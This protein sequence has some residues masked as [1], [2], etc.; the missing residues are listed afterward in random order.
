MGE[1]QNAYDIKAK[2]DS[3][4][5]DNRDLQNLFKQINDLKDLNW[6]ND[7]IDNVFDANNQLN[8][9]LKTALEG[10]KT[11]DIGTLVTEL[12]KIESGNLKLDNEVKG[13]IAKL[14]NLLQDILNEKQVNPASL[15]EFEWYIR[16]GKLN[17][18]NK[19]NSKEIGEIVKF[20][21][22]GG[23]NYDNAVQLYRNMDEQMRAHLSD[24]N[25]KKTDRSNFQAVMDALWKAYSSLSKPQTAVD[26]VREHDLDKI[27]S[28]KTPWYLE[29]LFN[30]Y[31]RKSN[32]E[33]W[34]GK[35]LD[36]NSSF[37]DNASKDNLSFTATQFVEKFNE[38]NKGRIDWA[39]EKW[40][41]F[42]NDANNHNKINFDNNW[43][44]DLDKSNDFKTAM[45]ADIVNQSEINSDHF[46]DVRKAWKDGY[47]AAVE[48][49]AKKGWKNIE[50]N[51][52]EFGKQTETWIKGINE[53]LENDQQFLK[54]EGTDSNTTISYNLEK[55]KNY[56]NSLLKVDEQNA[57]RNNF[58]T[59]TGPERKAWIAAV[60]IALNNLTG[61]TDGNKIKVDGIDQQQTENAVKKFQTDKDL[62]SKDGKPW[63][64]TIKALLGIDDS[65]SE[66][67]DESSGK[68]DNHENLGL[69]ENAN[70]I[71]KTDFNIPINATI[72]SKSW[73]NKWLYYKDGNNI[74]RVSTEDPWVKRTAGIPGQGAELPEASKMTLAENVCDKWADALNNIINISNVL[75]VSWLTFSVD[76]GKYVLKK[77]NNDVTLPTAFFTEKFCGATNMEDKLKLI[78]LGNDLATGQARVQKREIAGLEYLVV[79]DKYDINLSNLGD[80]NYNSLLTYAANSSPERSTT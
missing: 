41:K 16:D 63:P 10:F 62:E 13:S 54:I 7:T 80:D 43:K 9:S 71:K 48:A 11:K 20:I 52:N 51:S 28:E 6:S 30:L 72:Y 79:D 69:T 76:N 29:W 36:N 68:I 75:R 42:V 21:E 45:L 34:S 18:L 64:E 26:A 8:K 53:F 24:R 59:K 27:F 47:D 57:T 37:N 78:N 2:L 33:S 39:K 49:E 38:A 40:L 25:F 5:T 12:W 56:L 46:S 67:S 22:D 60:Q 61:V 74:V 73:D 32:D 14:K 55:A 70:I 65:S 35:P 3:K 77:W 58:K 1:T 17:N 66:S 19:L 23:L 4:D 15:N 31:I 50:K 44:I